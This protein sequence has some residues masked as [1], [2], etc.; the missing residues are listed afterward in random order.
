MVRRLV[1]NW[2]LICTASAEKPSG[3]G[4]ERSEGTPERKRGD[5]SF[6]LVEGALSS[7]RH[8]AFPARRKYRE[9]VILRSGGLLSPALRGLSVVICSGVFPTL[10]IQ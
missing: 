1:A 10:G 5:N 8:K 9:D 7:R 4:F 3:L 6:E 2:S